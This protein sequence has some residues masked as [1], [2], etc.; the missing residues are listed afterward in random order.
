VR[1]RIFGYNREEMVGFWRR[2]QNGELH[3]SYG[4]QNIVSVIKSRNM[5]WAG[6]VARMGAMINA[7]ETLVGLKGREHSEDLGV[8]G[9]ITEWI[10]KK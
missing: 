6:H 4:L 9:S 1:R 8:D 7:Y 5:R 2:Q 10:L 3:N